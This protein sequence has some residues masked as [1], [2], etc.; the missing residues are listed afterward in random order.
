MNEYKMRTVL[1]CIGMVQ[2]YTLLYKQFV[3]FQW[4][5]KEKRNR[6]TSRFISLILERASRSALTKCTI[7][8]AQQTFIWSI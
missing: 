7:T 1:K 8:S 2:S 3:R 6:K 5:Q 4:N